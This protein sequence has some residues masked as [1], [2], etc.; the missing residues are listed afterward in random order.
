M[1]VF[2]FSVDGLRAQD[3]DTVSEPV[4]EVIDLSGAT[5]LDPLLKQELMEG[6][7]PALGN[8]LESTEGLDPALFNEVGLGP[9]VQTVIAVVRDGP[10]PLSEM[11]APLLTRELD[12]LLGAGRY[13]LRDSDEFDASWDYDQAPVALDQALNDPEIDM[14]LAIGL[15]T[16]AAAADA[17]RVLNKPVIGANVLRSSVWGLEYG[18]DGRSEKEN[19]V[20]N[21][22][23]NGAV[24]DLQTFQDLTRFNKVYALVDQSEVGSQQRLQVAVREMEQQLDF[25]IGAILASPTIAETIRTIQAISP[26]AIYLTPLTRY[27]LEEQESLIAEI[28]RLKI[29]TFS[30]LG[31]FMVEKGALAGQSVF[32]PESLARRVALNIY[33]IER[34]SRPEELN[35]IISIDSRLVINAR[36]AKQIDFYPDFST[37]NSA[38]F[39]FQDELFDGRELQLVTAIRRARDNNVAVLI[40][41]ATT[42]R[43]EASKNVS[44]SNLLPQASIR[45]NYTR[46]DRDRADATGSA[47]WRHRAGFTASQSLFSDALIS[48]F[49]SSIKNFL[50]Q[51]AFEASVRLDAA[52]D[53]AQ[54]Y[55]DLLLA[56]ALL[57]VEVANLKLTQSNLQLAKLR[58]MAGVSGPEEVLRWRSE[59]ATGRGQVLDAE[60]LTKAALVALNQILNE[61]QST[62]WMPEDIML[63]TG[64]M[65][66]LDNQIRDIIT[67][68]R[69]LKDLREF[70]VRKALELSPTLKSIDHQI[71]GQQITLGERRRSFYLPELSME[72]TYDR[73][74]DGDYQFGRPANLDEDEWQALLVAEL[75]VFQGWRRPSEVNQERS[76]LERLIQLQ[77]E[78]SQLIEQNTRN[79]IFSMESSFPN[80]ELSRIALE[81]SRKN[82]DL[83]R[84]KYVEGKVGVT[85]LIDAQENTLNSERAAV[86]AVYVFLGDLYDYQRAI[87]WFEVE[88]SPQQQQEFV[89]QLKQFLEV[90]RIQTGGN[91]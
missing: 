11:L 30:M 48:D 7:D 26:E 29:P 53:G 56:R 4:M 21:M 61:D 40:E 76:E 73:E 23:P 14:V 5:G 80:I 6:L 74:L 65:Y 22:L 66:F 82:L 13:E 62:E 91:P 10:M 86:E 64:D 18:P 25:E 8:I 50:S 59:V 42:R 39:L 89:N 69:L 78:A 35:V 41:T 36:T 16:V 45:T 57:K 28:N 88:Q 34:G 84:D 55:L 63:E 83:V 70:S 87:S 51:K 46:T 19:L 27:S 37:A 85:D 20:F 2:A 79:A 75:P 49:R 17:S 67:N 32:N 58:E 77:I 1:A 38:D 72:V 43:T 9:D 12:E 47:R 81:S 60:A 24:Q 3:A 54:S 52:N 71:A 90:R 33:S 68:E 31:H 44:R 15:N